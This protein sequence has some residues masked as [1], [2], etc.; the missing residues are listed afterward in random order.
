MGF[1]SELFGN[2]KY[3]NINEEELQKMLKKNK[4]VLILDVR[5]IGEFRSGHIPKSKNIP[6]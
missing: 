6:V 5:T 3:T 2:K 1:L 4:G